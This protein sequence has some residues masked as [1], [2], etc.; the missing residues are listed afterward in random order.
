M[1][2]VTAR[3]LTAT[4]VALLAACAPAHDAQD[5]LTQIQSQD[6]EVRQDAKEKIAAILRSGD[7]EVFERAAREGDG[8][9]RVQS[10][11]YL[12]RFTEPGAREAL[13]GLLAV[14][15]RGMIPYS[16]IRM[17][18]TSELTDSRILVAHL[19]RQNGGDPQALDVLLA[20]LDT[21][22]SPEIVTGTCFALGALRDPRGVP[23][24]RSATASG[25]TAVVRAAV[26]A[27]TRIA[28]AEALDALQ[29]VADHPSFE[30][31]TDLL[32]ALDLR[33]DPG[34]APIIRRFALSDPASEVR[35]Q[36][37]QQVARFPV[38]QAVPALIEILRDRTPEVRAVA[39]D[40]LVR[41]AG[42]SL[43]PRPE[44]WTRW[45]AANQKRLAPTAG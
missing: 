11:L 9:V 14:Q 32:L 35:A 8:M 37:A 42:K 15:H 19:I 10:I 34:V 39:H 22:Q 1:R 25:E 23:Y 5:L 45:W 6:S 12:A 38:D 7:F 16:P 43:A 31:R 18:V 3:M 41:I 2:H 20:G 44:I 27:L 4:A 26:E 33:D 24:L 17:R 40:A 36:A 21:R 30:V 13:R 29:G 28:G